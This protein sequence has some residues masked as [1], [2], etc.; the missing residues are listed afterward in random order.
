MNW[1]FG[2]SEMM[3]VEITGTEY[4]YSYRG[5]GAPPPP[6]KMRVL[7]SPSDACSMDGYNTAYLFYEQAPCVA[8]VK[9]SLSKL[10]SMLPIFS[11]T[12]FVRF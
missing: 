1:L 3:E 5:K 8:Q 12:I 11:G 7:L 9:E 2:S 4:I 10:L 6:E